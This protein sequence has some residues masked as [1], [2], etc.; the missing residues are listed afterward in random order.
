[1]IE[2]PIRDTESA[3]SWGLVQQVFLEGAFENDLAALCDVLATNAPLSLRG[4]K[5]A[6]INYRH[7]RQ[8]DRDSA[9]AAMYEAIA[10]CLNSDDVREGR[11][12]FR[13]HRRPRFQG[14]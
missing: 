6:L 14:K 12:A 10:A 1:M 4:T 9:S 13:E 7:D 11:A 5:Q 3:R 2:I 8:A